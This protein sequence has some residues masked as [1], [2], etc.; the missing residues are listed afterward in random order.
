MGSLIETKGT[1]RLARLFNSERFDSTNIVTMRGIVGLTT[2]FGSNSDQRSLLSISDQFR[3]KWT[4]GADALYPSATVTTVQA[5]IAANRL[6]FTQRLPTF[7]QNGMSIHNETQ[8]GIPRHTTIS[9]LQNTAGGPWTVDTNNPVTA[10]A[11]DTIVFSYAPHPNLIKR[12]RY[13]LQNELDPANHSLIQNAIF[14]ALNDPSY[15][16][17]R[18]TVLEDATQRVISQRAYNTNNPTDDN[19]DPQHQ[20]MHII[21]LTKATNAP[22]PLDPQ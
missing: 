20:H 13:Y 2:A 22:D 6:T 21:L 5:V 19:I 10:S 16:H 14:T 8:P 7:V 4:G 11:G 15:T 18:F 17:I 3:N 12:W 9:N 1:Q